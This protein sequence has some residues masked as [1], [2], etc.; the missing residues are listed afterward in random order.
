MTA[1]MSGFDANVEPAIGPMRFFESLEI[2]WV[3]AGAATEAIE[4]SN[5]A[6]CE[7]HPSDAWAGPNGFWLK[8]RGPSTTSQG[9]S[10]FTEAMV[11]L[12]AP[13]FST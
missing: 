9:G 6:A 3:Q 4:L 11:I 13:G 5:V 1:E 12:I 2:S 7:V 8:V 10:S